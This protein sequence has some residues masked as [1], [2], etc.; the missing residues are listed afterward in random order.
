VL[1]ANF[2]VRPG[3]RPDATLEALG[4]VRAEIHDLVRAA[5]PGLG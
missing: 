2:F 3:A 5:F 1:L 4:R